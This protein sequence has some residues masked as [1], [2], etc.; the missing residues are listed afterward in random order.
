LV[1]QTVANL[2]LLKGSVNLIYKNKETA[3]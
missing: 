2:W 1:T 3:N